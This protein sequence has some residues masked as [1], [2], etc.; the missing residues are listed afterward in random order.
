MK[1]SK[2]EELFPAM[3]TD[4]FDTNRFFPNHWFERESN[5]LPAVNVK[6]DGKQFDIEFAAPGFSK[7][8]F[9]IDLD[10]NV[11]TVSAEKKQEKNEDGKR[12]T[13]REFS[14]NTF[15]RSFTLPQTVNADKIDA[16]YQHGL[17]RL[18]IPKKDEVKS[19]PKKQIQIS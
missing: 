14:Y 17:L 16:K 3:L 11:L 7:E 13:R 5:N 9:K 8:D 1:T 4:F 6:E 19:L 15:S 2:K 12:F 10:Q 18:Q